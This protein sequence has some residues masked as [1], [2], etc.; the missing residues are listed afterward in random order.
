MSTDARLFGP[1]RL[2]CGDRRLLRG[3]EAIDLPA[4]YMDALILLVKA[5]GALV[6]KDSFMHEV[7]RGV[8]VTDEAL[9]QAIRTLRKAL[10]DSAAAP[11]FIETV[12]KHGY[13][14]IA[15]LD[16]PAPARQP[17]PTAM[18]VRDSIV[19]R[20][21]AGIAGAL[22]AG[23]LVGLLYG[24][25][26]ATHSGAGGTVSLF[27][28]IALVSALSAGAAGAGIAVGIALSYNVRPHGWHWRVAGAALGGVTLG[29]VA[30]MIGR[31][32]IRLLFGQAIGEF[33]GAL[34]GFVV[35]AAT[36]LA[37]V[38]TQQRIRYSAGMAAL[39]GAAAGLIVILLDG[40]MMAGSLQTLVSAFPSS[41]FRFDGLGRL[42]GERGFGASSRMVT[43]AFEGAVFVVAMVQAMSHSLGNGGSRQ[44]PDLP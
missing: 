43:A 33:S 41:Q 15:P 17:E 37:L 25:A 20:T 32:T 11:Q 24:F 36:G 44:A 42:L 40:R 35:G 7:W 6:T 30:N 19:G 31:D 3:T 28:V 21:S 22:L 13:R 18:L 23:A 8:P 5:E 9:T 12:P 16:L 29:A 34:E 1:F 14:F 39:L 4:R 26:G 10:G 38:L 27:L 2:E